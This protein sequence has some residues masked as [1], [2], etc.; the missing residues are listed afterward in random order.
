MIVV[1]LRAASPHAK[2][3]GKSDRPRESLVAK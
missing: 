2:L 3:V 1:V